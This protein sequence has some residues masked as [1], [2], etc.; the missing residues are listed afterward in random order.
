MAVSEYIKQLQ[1]Y[2]EYAFSWDELL[3]NNDAPEPTIRKELARLADKNEILNLRQGFYLIMPP[4]YQSLGKLPIQLYIDKLFKYLNKD[5]YAGLYTAAAFYG[6]SHQQIQ[7]DYVIT[8]SPALRDINKN[9]TKLRFFKTGHWPKKNILQKK[10]DAG[11]FN[12]SSPALTAIDL[13]HHQAKIGG[14]SRLLSNLEELAEEITHEDM[15]NL[16]SWYSNKS[17]LQRFGYLMEEIEVQE[18][19][20]QL[21]YDR[22]KNERFY[23][24]LL[25]PKKGQKA[26]STGN[27]WK[28]DVNIKLENDL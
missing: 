5:Y 28:V 20:P 4:R 10:S 1:S 8:V 22:L 17:T 15:E 26:G 2:E 13:V 23:P 24:V 18:S 16:L 7:Q 14:I 3:K 25:S 6:A 9:K 21:I 12:I 11:L 19:I 27:R